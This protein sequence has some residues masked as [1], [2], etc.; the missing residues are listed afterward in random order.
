MAVYA[1]SIQAKVNGTAQAVPLRDSD[2]QEKIG[3]LS[4]ENIKHNNILSQVSTTYTNINNS[5]YEIGFINPDG[6]LQ[7]YTDCYSVF[8]LIV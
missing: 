6:S 2:A 1:D 8:D 4:E 7:G 3:S 5:G